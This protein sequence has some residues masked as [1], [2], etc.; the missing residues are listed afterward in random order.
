[1]YPSIFEMTKSLLLSNVH[2]GCCFS[3][4][5]RRHDLSR[6][7]PNLENGEWG[8]LLVSITNLALT[9]CLYVMGVRVFVFERYHTCTLMF[10]F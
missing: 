8:E 3:I 7:V 2:A 1:M 9:V 5:T 4:R 10:L 6:Q